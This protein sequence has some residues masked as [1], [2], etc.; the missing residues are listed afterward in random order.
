MA[1]E[2]NL[3]E[4]EVI[5]MTSTTTPVAKTSVLIVDDD[6]FS[7]AIFCKNLRIL[8]MTDIQEAM[9]GR[10][11][12]DQ[13]PKPPDFMICDIFMPDMDGI[14]FVGELAKRNYQGGL[15]LVTGVNQVML[16]VA[17]D[18]ALLKGLQVLGTF[19][20]QVQQEALRKVLGLTA[21]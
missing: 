11:G 6:E 2:L 15:I 16:D 13:M 21:V 5:D 1:L 3:N 14:E 8:G 17:A 20:K 12:V 4:Q 18:I 9:N 7:R 19:T 10:A